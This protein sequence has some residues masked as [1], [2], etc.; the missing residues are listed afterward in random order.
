MAKDS[1]EP[2]DTALAAYK[3]GIVDRQ[4]KQDQH[5]KDTAT[6]QQV[7][8]ANAASLQKAEDDE[9]ASKA[10]F[11]AALVEEHRLENE[12][13]AA[14]VAHEPPELPAVG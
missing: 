2:V 1:L 5:N 6:L 9:K 7:L 3:A 12:F 8:E 11:F 4:L 14:A 10:A 13:E